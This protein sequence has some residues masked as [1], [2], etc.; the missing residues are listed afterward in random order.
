VPRSYGRLTRTRTGISRELRT[1]IRQLSWLVAETKVVMT[2]QHLDT[3]HTLETARIHLDD[4]AIAKAVGLTK[5]YGEGGAAVVAQD[6]Q[7]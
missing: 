7:R 4:E 5:V 6:V 2:L 1:L 3:S